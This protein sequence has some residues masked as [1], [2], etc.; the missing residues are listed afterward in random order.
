MRRIMYPDKKV[1]PIIIKRSIVRKTSLF[2]YSDCVVS[3]KPGI[4]ID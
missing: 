3:A 1:A 4:R 2:S